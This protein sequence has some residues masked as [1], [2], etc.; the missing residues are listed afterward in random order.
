MPAS[1]LIVDDEQGIRDLLTW[2]LEG[3]GYQVV[4]AAD[5]AGALQALAHAE[6]DLVISDVRMPGLSGLELLRKAKE[7]APDTDV[8]IASAFADPEYTLECLRGGA[9]DF[10][11]KPFDAN[12]LLATVERALERR[13]LREAA[14]LCETSRAIL[15]SLET[16]HLPER[17]VEV[18]RR[19]MNADDVS[20]M[21]P[22][23][24][25]RLYI[26]HSHGLTAEVQAEVRVA[27]GERVAGRIAALRTPVLIADGL[28]I[29]P[30]FRDVP[31]FGR[32]RSSIIF[33]LTAGERLVGV[34]NIW[35][36]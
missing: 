20:L 1:V 4:A 10:I 7:L 3:H 28:L 19:V 5:G 6:F 13:Q 18:A 30:M 11:Q 34:L 2:E 29:E 27:L 17:I 33:P 9:F 36:S 21:L 22:D 14:A 31:S 35:L 24:D 16:Q 25:G 32:V 23:P 26:A 15:G 12:H 8:L